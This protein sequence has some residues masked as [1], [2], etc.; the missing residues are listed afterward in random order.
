MALKQLALVLFAMAVV[1]PAWA[2]SVRVEIYNNTAVDLCVD[3]KSPQQCA[4]MQPTQTRRVSLH[5]RHWINFGME[6]REYRLPK[7]LVDEYS[8]TNSPSLKLQAEPDGKLYL[9]PRDVAFP[10]RP[11]PRQPSGFPLKPKRV[12]DLT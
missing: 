9:V 11:L 5:H 4:E 8:K 2:Q 6:S 10:A 7:T 12:V 3:G 1:F